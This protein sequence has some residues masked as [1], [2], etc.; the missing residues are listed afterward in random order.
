MGCCNNHQPPMPP[1]ASGVNPP[2]YPG[3]MGTSCPFKST[4]P[5]V[6]PVKPGI[7]ALPCNQCVFRRVL[8]P[9]TMGDDT[10]V[11]PA[12]LEYR[13]VILE[14]EYNNHVYIFSSDGVPVLISNGTGT[15]FN[16]LTNRPMYNGEPMDGLTNIPEVPT[17]I[18]Q[19]SDAAR[20]TCIEST[21]QSLKQSYEIMNKAITNLTQ[22]VDTQGDTLVNLSNEIERVDC[23]KQDKLV[24]EGPNQNIKTVNGMS[25][26][27]QGNIEV[28][29]ESAG[30]QPVLVSGEN[31]KTVN[32]QDILGSGNI[33]IQ[34]NGYTEAEA[35]AKFAAW[36]TFDGNRKALQLNNYDSIF[37]LDTN[38]VGHN[39]AM[40]SKWNIADFGAAGLH[41]NLN[42][43]DR[44]TIN[45][46]E[47]IVTSED[48]LT[49]A[50]FE[51]MWNS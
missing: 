33:E 31:I 40:V 18:A 43:S 51:S 22:T 17:A 50:E 11:P 19:L 41:L 39:L 37:G 6:P 24:G 36:A 35:D 9:S 27:G 29:L 2:P 38:G 5:P 4:L 48:A 47:T 49:P 20:I 45:D 25:L 8:F 16:D 42:S 23:A 10:T 30:V 14:Y 1:S 46:S 12:T 44:A 32:G 28:T 21:N 7:C 15:N 13:N 34:S 3:P 26:V